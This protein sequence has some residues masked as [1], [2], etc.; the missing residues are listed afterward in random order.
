VKKEKGS[1][2]GSERKGERG[3]TMAIKKGRKKRQN[4]AKKDKDKRSFYGTEKRFV[5]VKRREGERFKKHQTRKRKGAGVVDQKRE[6]PD[7]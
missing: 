4:T 6:K 2:T 5:A 3:E 7:T 1:H